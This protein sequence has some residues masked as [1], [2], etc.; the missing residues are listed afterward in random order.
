M[1]VCPKEKLP[2]CSF[3]SLD[4]LRSPFIKLAV[5]KPLSTVIGSATHHPNA[6][7]CNHRFYFWRAGQWSAYFLGESGSGPMETTEDSLA[8]HFAIKV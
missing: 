1:F 4:P 7:L 2:L 8:F 3:L 5:G 6:P